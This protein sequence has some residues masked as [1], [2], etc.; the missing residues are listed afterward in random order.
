MSILIK[1]RKVNERG[2]FAIYP[3]DGHW[4][5]EDGKVSLIGQLLRIKARTN[6]EAVRLAADKLNRFD[7]WSIEIVGDDRIMD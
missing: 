5:T 7:I 2:W 6:N 1:S 3:R 4:L